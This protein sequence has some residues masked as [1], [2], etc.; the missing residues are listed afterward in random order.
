MQYTTN[1]TV[2]SFEKR[3]YNTTHLCFGKWISFSKIQITTIIQSIVP[4]LSFFSL[5]IFS[6]IAIEQPLIAIHRDVIPDSQKP[7]HSPSGQI[8][9]CDSRGDIIGHWCPSR[10]IIIKI[11]VQYERWRLLTT[12]SLTYTLWIRSDSCNRKRVHFLSS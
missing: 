1:L 6:S 4:R 2:A 12:I 3:I 10:R 8:I 9:E 11:N 5:R 7:Q